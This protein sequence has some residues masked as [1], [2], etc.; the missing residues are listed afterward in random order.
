MIYRREIDGLRAIA[1]LPVIL[2]HAGFQRF[3]GGFV[4]VDIF[5]VISG[6]LI[7]SIIV[8]ELQQ[9]KFRISNFYERRARRI[10]PALLFVLLCSM[11][12]AA[13]TMLPGEIKSFSNS[14]L[15]VFTFTSNIFFWWETGYFDSAAELKPLL[16]TWSLSVEEQY[17]IFFPLIAMAVFARK[18]KYLPHVIFLIFLVSLIGSEWATTNKPDAGYFLLPTRAWEILTGALAAIYKPENSFISNFRPIVKEALSLIGLGLI[19]IPIVKYNEAM[20]FP[21]INAIPPVFGAALV[22]M[23][24]TRE[25]IAGKILGTSALVWIGLI[26]Y[27]AY[28]WHQPLFAFARLAYG[29]VSKTA[30]IALILTTLALAYLTWRFVEA[31]FRNK[32]AVRAKP[33]I[34]TASIATAALATFCVSVSLTS[35]FLSLYKPENR[36]LAS[37]E[38]FE[39]GEYVRSRFNNLLMKEFDQHSDKKK[40]L[41]IGD[42][43]AQDLINA[44]YEAG[45]DA[46]LDIITRHISAKCGNIFAPRDF[47]R[48]SMSKSQIRKCSDPVNDLYNDSKLRSLMMQS[49]QVWLASNWKTWQAEI[50]PVGIENIKKETGKQT[51]VFGPK[52]FGSYTIKNLIDLSASE[53]PGFELPVS[54]EILQTNDVMK[55]NIDKTATSTC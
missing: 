22:L 30:Y 13:L 41:L 53:R 31:P 39:T 2:F 51:I 50:L 43:Y 34:A 3:S 35:G 36:T 49:D 11:G 9:E 38:P 37:I 42:S 52:N 45:V 47:I 29:D 23:F 18:P 17:Y 15:S 16:H 27:S 12:L 55:K 26:S 32:K 4:G 10:L 1:V 25:T 8:S 19:A 21:G 6:Y 14:V 20:A 7:T 48:Q 28:L 24:A 44:I 40:I 33:A 46:K 5:F 54:K